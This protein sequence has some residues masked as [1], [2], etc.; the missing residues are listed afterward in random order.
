MTSITQNAP[1]RAWRS[2]ANWIKISRD[3][4]PLLDHVPK[5]L[6]DHLARDVGLTA[7]DLAKLRH[8]WPSMQH[9]RGL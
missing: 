3:T 1:W 2:F 4:P 6:S 7:H 8:E 9:H 5:D